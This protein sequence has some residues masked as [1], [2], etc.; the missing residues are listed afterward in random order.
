MFFHNLANFRY[1]TKNDHFTLSNT[2]GIPKIIKCIP[3]NTIGGKGKKT[4]DMAVDVIMKNHGCDF[5]SN[6]VHPVF[7]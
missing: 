4:L 3:I 7:T 1:F 6:V 5:F 2:Y